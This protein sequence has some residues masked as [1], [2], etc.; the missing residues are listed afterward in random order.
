MIF[1]IF[2]I[3]NM[4]KIFILDVNIEHSILSNPNSGS[5]FYHLVAVNKTVFQG[6]L[7]IPSK[8]W[9]DHYQGK[10]TMQLRCTTLSAL[11]LN[12]R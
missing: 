5:T 8:L 4:Y 11:L 7:I 9:A 12:M 2:L 1:C 3:L 10:F 6:G